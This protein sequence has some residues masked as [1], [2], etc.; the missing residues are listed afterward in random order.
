MAM[1][2]AHNDARNQRRGGERDFEV[3]HASIMQDAALEHS[4][5]KGLIWR[6]AWDRWIDLA[7]RK[8][9]RSLG[10]SGEEADRD[11]DECGLNFGPGHAAIATLVYGSLPQGA[12]SSSRVDADTGADA[13]ACIDQNRSSNAPSSLSMPSAHPELNKVWSRAELGVAPCEITEKVFRALLAQS[14]YSASSQPSILQWNHREAAALLLPA[15]YDLQSTLCSNAI[16][17]DTMQVFIPSS[18]RLGHQAPRGRAI[19]AERTF[20]RPGSPMLWS[21]YASALFAAGETMASRAADAKAES[22]GFGQGGWNAH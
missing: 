22:L 15:Q 19:L 2:I 5:R 9:M 12:S 10:A 18:C 7:A 8:G 21:E 14:L 3:E 17:A 11:V 13:D 4:D 6:M 16:L 20:L 1:L